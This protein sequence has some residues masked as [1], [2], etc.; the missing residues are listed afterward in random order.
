VDESQVGMAL[1]VHH[2]YPDEEANGVAT[3]DATFDRRFRA[4]RQILSR[5][6]ARHL[7]RIPKAMP[8]Q[9]WCVPANSARNPSF[10]D[11]QSLQPSSL[12]GPT[13]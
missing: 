8:C 1:L 5:R 12:L 2:S 10:H 7:S 9:S 3:M 4:M 11:R 13:C 6:S